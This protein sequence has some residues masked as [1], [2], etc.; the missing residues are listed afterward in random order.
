MTDRAMFKGRR[1]PTPAAGEDRGSRVAWIAFPTDYLSGA[2]DSGVKDVAWIEA[3]PAGGATYIEVVFTRES[4]ER[5]HR[6][7]RERQERD[8][9]T[10][11]RLLFDEALFVRYYH[12]DWEN[13]DLSMPGDGKVADLVFSAL[14]PHDTGRP[15]RIR[16]GPAPSDG[17]ALVLQELGGYPIDAGPKP[18]L[19]RMRDETVRPQLDLST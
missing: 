16:F 5:V 12:A 19:Q 17:D 11:L 1:L 10:Y 7:F 8:V 3:A 14:D 15:I 13:K 6:A 18:E 9:L 4:Q 2:F